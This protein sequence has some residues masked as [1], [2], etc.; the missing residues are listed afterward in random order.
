M[1]WLRTFVYILWPGAFVS[2]R[3]G[4]GVRYLGCAVDVFNFFLNTKLSS[5]VVCHFPS[6]PAVCVFPLLHSSANTW[7]VKLLHCSCPHRYMVVIICI[8]LITND[9]EHFLC[10]SLPS[11]YLLVRCPH[12]LSISK[13][14][15]LSRT[16]KGLRFYPFCRLSFMDVGRRHE[17]PKSQRK[18]FISLA[19]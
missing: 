8:S 14:G 5:K 6:Q 4:L 10:A 13:I 17:L 7:Y 15:L 11:V 3:K 1:K 16:V 18:D 12:L 9:V 2:L 19:A